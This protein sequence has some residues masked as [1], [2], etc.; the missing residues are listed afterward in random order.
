MSGLNCFLIVCFYATIVF[1][2]L[3]FPLCVNEPMLLV[4]CK[5]ERWNEV[6]GVIYVL[7]SGWDFHLYQMPLS[8][9]TLQTGL[10]I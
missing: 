7:E 6:L 10:W 4:V 3:S 2:C 1:P 8:P 5:E 9:F